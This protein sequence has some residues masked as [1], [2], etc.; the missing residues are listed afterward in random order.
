MRSSVF[1]V[2]FL[3][4]NGLWILH[5]VYQRNERE[6]SKKNM[7]ANS[8]IFHPDLTPIWGAAATDWV[9]DGEDDRTFAQFFEDT[10]DMIR[11]AAQ[12]QK[13]HPL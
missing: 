7:Q 10:V 13:Q 5:W 6:R 12:A 4:T 11:R 9:T 3:V 1:E 8:Q 2:L